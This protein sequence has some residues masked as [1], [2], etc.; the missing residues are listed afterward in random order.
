MKK[1][2]LTVILLSILLTSCGKKGALYLPQDAAQ[3]KENDNQDA[4]K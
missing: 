3:Q 4:A 2:F 1:L